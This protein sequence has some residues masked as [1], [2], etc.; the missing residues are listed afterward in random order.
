MNSNRDSRLHQTTH[1][2]THTHACT[3]THIR[4]HLVYAHA[5]SQD[6]RVRM[7]YIIRRETAHMNKGCP[8]MRYNVACRKLYPSTDLHTCTY[9][10]YNVVEL[11]LHV[12][13]QIKGTNHDL[14]KFNGTTSLA[15]E[16]RKLCLWLTFSRMNDR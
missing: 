13:T 6:S 12:H 11:S 14:L 1:T 8:G 10:H 5:H 2:C 3:H 9:D 15:I 4:A 7:K 16:L